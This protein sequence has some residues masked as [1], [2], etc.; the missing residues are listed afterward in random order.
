M[1]K[2]KDNIVKNKFY[3][4]IA[5]L[6][7]GVI[8]FINN[9]FD[10]SKGTQ[11]IVEHGGGDAGVI[12]SITKD[13]TVEQNVIADYDK[14]NCVSLKMATY[15]RNNIG[16]INVSL[17]DSNGNIVFS[18]DK[19]MQD[20]DDNSWVDFSFRE[21]S[22]SKNQQ[23]TLRVTSQD[24]ENEN[25]VTIYYGKS[26]ESEAVINGV[27]QEGTLNIT[28]KYQDTNLRM[29]KMICWLLVILASIILSINISECNEKMFLKF[30]IVYG[31]LL[32]F[33]SPFPHALDESTHFFRSY[34]ISQG[35]FYDTTLYNNIGGYVPDNYGQI[36]GKRLSILD[37]VCNSDTFGQSFSEEK[38]FYTNPYM[39]SV[40]PFNHSIGAIGILLGNIFRLPAFIVIIMGRMCDLAFYT[41]FCYLAIKKAK[42]YKSMFFMVATLPIA[43]FLAGSYS[44]DPILISS[45]LLFT[46]ICFKY[47]FEKEQM[48][49]KSEMVLLI[50]CGLFIASVKYL[51]Y[52]PILLLFF[53]IP[54]KCFGKKRYIVELLSAVILIIGM[55]FLQIKGLK[56]FEFTEDRNGDV[57]VARQ[58]DYILENKILSCRNFLQYFLS[59]SFEHIKNVGY[60]DIGGVPVV[61]SYIGVLTLMAS[62]LGKDKYVFADN[63]K[64]R[65]FGSLLLFILI[66][67]FGVTIV[68]LYVGFTP[69]G[70]FAVEGVQTRYL[71]PVILFLM[72]PLSFINVNNNIKNYETKISFMMN[73]G[74]INLLSGLLLV[75]FS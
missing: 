59:S 45:S 47:Y 28:M 69:V 21:L 17:L 26:E 70:K 3:L 15:A 22:N 64:K 32:V 74:M 67:V 27:R 63:R 71:T 6:F 33:V 55:I 38:T 18:Q 11:R 31:C 30:A 37:Y 52:T 12:E 62:I 14:L 72:I 1:N 25:A 19:N 23:Y 40:T 4:V 61:T 5:L 68:A 29:L 36:L 24:A 46:S 56:M 35:D 34:M 7:W 2:I 54:Q 58:I 9:P 50:L 48:M 65:I 41:V 13:K 49:S 66:V 42:Y 8:I 57:D 60:V 43:L 39:S 75:V 53:L 20:I 44:I 10:I 51:V 16:T 73:V